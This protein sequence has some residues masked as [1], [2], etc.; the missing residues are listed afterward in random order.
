MGPPRR[1]R[2]EQD[3]FAAT[4]EELPEVCEA[5]HRL[6]PGRM[7]VGWLP[8]GCTPGFLGHRSVTCL[9]CGVVWYRPGHQPEAEPVW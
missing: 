4:A 1:R 6:G 5:G 2:R 8:C 3:E 7:L 9:E